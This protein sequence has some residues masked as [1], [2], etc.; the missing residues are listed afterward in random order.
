M[1]LLSKQPN[2]LPPQTDPVADVDIRNTVVSFRK[3]NGELCL[4]RE[5]SS[6]EK[7]VLQ[8]REKE[9]ADALLPY[10]LEELDLVVAEVAMTAACFPRMRMEG[11][12]AAKIYTGAASQVLERYPRWAVS[13][14]CSLIREGEAGLER[15]DDAP[16]VPQLNQITKKV[17]AGY[18]FRLEQA[19]ELLSAKVK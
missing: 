5:L 11:Q 2:G 1:R 19:R 7:R 15:L 13:K 14:A 3:D 17:T 6:G 10:S 8:A 12:D 4:S 18:R 16:S 9:L